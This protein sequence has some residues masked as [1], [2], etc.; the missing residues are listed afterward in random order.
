VT[1][2]TLSD[3][4]IPKDGDSVD[5]SIPSC[6]SICHD[7]S[8]THDDSFTIDPPST[9]AFLETLC[10]TESGP[11]ACKCNNN[12]P[13]PS[14]LLLHEEEDNFSDAL[15]LPEDV[16]YDA[17]AYSSDGYLEPPPPLVAI[18]DVYP[19]DPFVFTNN[20]VIVGTHQASF[21]VSVIGNIE[22]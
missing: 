9:Q 19:E 13:D 2:C 21:N 11:V 20:G 7:D 8:I 3:D 10:V 1:S 17:Q 6:D 14:V 16:F 15:E 22:T 4:S 5:G 18:W 12:D